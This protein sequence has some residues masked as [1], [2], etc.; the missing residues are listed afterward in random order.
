M[1]IYLFLPDFR[2]LIHGT[3]YTSA[4]VYHYVFYYETLNKIS[5]Y[6]PIGNVLYCVELNKAE[7]PMT[8]QIN[9]LKQEFGA[10]EIPKEIMPFKQMKFEVE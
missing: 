1:K 4:D 7:L 6:K 3:I 5:F 9:E 8:I 10:I 2:S